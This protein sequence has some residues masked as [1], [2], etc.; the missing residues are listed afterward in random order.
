MPKEF[1]STGVEIGGF[2]W[3]NVL[4][5]NVGRIF[6]STEGRIDKLPETGKTRRKTG[7]VYM[8]QTTRCCSLAA[9]TGILGAAAAAVRSL[10]FK[11][12]ME[13][14]GFL[15]PFHPMQILFWIMA[16]VMLLTALLFSLKLPKISR[17]A[18]MGVYTGLTQILLGLCLGL[19]AVRLSPDLRFYRSL[20]LLGW[21]CCAVF[22]ADG[23]CRCVHKKLGILP[24]SLFCIFL[25]LYSVDLYAQW[26]NVPEMERVLV[27]AV[28]QI[29]LTVL[30]CEKAYW[31]FGQNHDGRLLFLSSAA[32][33][34]CMAA[35]GCPGVQVLHLGGIVWS[36]STVLSLRGEGEL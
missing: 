3:Y 29:L 26:S 12:A 34:F 17:Q 22:L 18:P 1:L 6:K 30:S 8:K 28:G 32:G 24:H 21:G 15:T 36:L 2:N 31:D 9:V 20:Q 33:F 10:Y 16:A 23:L 25:L 14:G 19:T 7:D 13:S 35:V 4:E 5:S 27:P 11:D